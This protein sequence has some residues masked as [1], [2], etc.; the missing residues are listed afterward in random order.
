MELDYL[1]NPPRGCSC[2]FGYAAIAPLLKECQLL[3]IVR[4]HQ[5]KEEVRV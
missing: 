1:P 5:C 3:G 2:F 4:A